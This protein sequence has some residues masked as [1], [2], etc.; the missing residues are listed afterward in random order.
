MTS[1]LQPVKSRFCLNI[2]RRNRLHLTDFG[3][4]LFYPGMLFNSDDKWWG[5][6]S[7]RGT[8][9]E[10]LDLSLYRD[11]NGR[12][13]SLES[14]TMVPVMYDGEVVRVINDFLG[15]TIFVRHS[16]FGNSVQDF[17]T[18]YGH[19][20]PS[21]NVARGVIL[22]EGELLGS[23]AD[24]SGSR[25]GLPPHLHISVALISKEITGDMLDWAAM[26]DLRRVKLFDPLA[27]LDCQF[28]MA[29]IDRVR[30]LHT[31]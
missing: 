29:A 7:A 2:L 4:W 19:V 17:Y 15:K 12:N 22:S 3:E 27:F 1:D 25:S 9:H 14:G 13:L 31:G 20:M 5:D 10:G 11:H 24:T 16:K 6:L 18:V 21:R 23:I 28:T 30:D 8:P 26:R